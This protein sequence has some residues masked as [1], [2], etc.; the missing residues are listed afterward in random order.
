MGLSL[1]FDFVWFGLILVRCWFGCVW[2]GSWVGGFGLVFGFDRSS[3][4]LLGLAFS[5]GHTWGLV[6]GFVEFKLGLYLF[7]FSTVSRTRPPRHPCPPSPQ[8]FHGG[9]LPL[10]FR[11]SGGVAATVAAGTEMKR[12]GGGKSSYAERYERRMDI[13]PITLLAALTKKSNYAE[14]FANILDTTQLCYFVLL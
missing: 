7:L 3:I 2:F 10:P 12:G 1:E 11:R 4:R 6:C 14:F 5:F 9:F 13:N 8:P